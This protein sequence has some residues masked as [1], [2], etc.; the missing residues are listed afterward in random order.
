MATESRLHSALGLTISFACCCR[1]AATTIAT[2]SNQGCLALATAPRFTR[3]RVVC[4]LKPVFLAY[5]RSASLA[6]VCQPRPLARYAAAT[7]RSTRKLMSS[8]VGVFCGPRWPRYRR[9]AAAVSFGSTSMSGRAA[10]ISS[11]VRSGF[12]G[13][14]RL[15]FLRICALLSLVGT[16]QTD[17]PNAVSSWRDDGGVQQA[18]DVAQHP[19]PLLA[20][21][22][23]VSSTLTAGVDVEVAEA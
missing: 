12:S 15:A 23:R 19:Q 3:V 4:P 20:V 2:I 7:S 18:V 8:F 21:G 11:A 16:P 14:G 6:R 5:I 13:S 1:S 17:D 10:R 9:T 22:L